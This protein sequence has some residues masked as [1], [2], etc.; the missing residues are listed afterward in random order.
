MAAQRR[1][2]DDLVAFPLEFVSHAW[3]QF[4]GVFADLTTLPKRQVIA[5][6]HPA[7]NLCGYA[8]AIEYDLCHSRFSPASAP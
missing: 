3:Q 2:V 8:R 7:R 4:A 1:V 5:L 6:D